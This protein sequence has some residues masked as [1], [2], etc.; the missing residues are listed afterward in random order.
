M[1]INYV[2]ALLAERLA[3][4]L[5]QLTAKKKCLSVLVSACVSVGTMTGE[6]IK[7]GG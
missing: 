3:K 4:P 7:L 5:T 1:D 2:P 6:R